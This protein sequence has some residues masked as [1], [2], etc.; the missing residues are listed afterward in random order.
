MRSGFRALLRRPPPKKY[1]AHLDA[2][3]GIFWVH[4]VLVAQRARELAI[5]LCDR[6]D[7]VVEIGADS[8]SDSKLKWPGGQC[9]RKICILELPIISTM[10]EMAEYPSGTLARLQGKVQSITRHTETV[11]DRAVDRHTLVLVNPLEPNQ[12]L[13]VELFSR[14]AARTQHNPKTGAFAVEWV[15]LKVDQDLDVTGTWSDLDQQLHVNVP[16][17][18]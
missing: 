10:V 14:H 17:L 8:S 5:Q 11:S 16:L 12:T 4:F 2:N 3:N 18:Q 15:E 9:M 7:D 13:T 1:V 6:F